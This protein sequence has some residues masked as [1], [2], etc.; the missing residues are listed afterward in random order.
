[1]M[2]SF[3]GMRTDDLAGSQSDRAVTLKQEVK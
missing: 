1:M 2:K 3:F